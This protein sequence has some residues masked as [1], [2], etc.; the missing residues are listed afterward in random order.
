MKLST[1]TKGM[2]AAERK[3]YASVLRVRDEFIRDFNCAAF[4]SMMS[5]MGLRLNSR[6]QSPMRVSLKGGLQIEVNPEQFN[7]MQPQ[8]Q[9]GA[10]EHELGHVQ[11]CLWRRVDE[12]RNQ[13][14]SAVADPKR[15]NLAADA[16]V[17]Q[18]IP[19]ERVMTADKC[20]GVSWVL[21]EMLPG[22]NDTTMPEGLSFEKYLTQTVWPEAPEG[23]QPGQGQPRD[24]E[25]EP[26]EG[27]GQGDGEGSNKPDKAKSGTPRTGDDQQPPENK[28][29]GDDK[30]G[31]PEDKDGP[32][33]QHSPK[34]AGEDPNPH[35]GMLGEDI[36]DGDRDQA[37]ADVQQMADQVKHDG[38]ARPGTESANVLER[39]ERN[40]RPRN[41]TDWRSQLRR[42]LVHLGQAHKQFSYA[43]VNRRLGT[44]GD[45][46]GTG[47][48]KVLL[49]ID[50]SGSM[51]R[52]A[53]ML[54]C[55]QV[56]LLADFLKVD[57]LVGQCDTAVQSV[58]LYD[59]ERVRKIQGG[60]G[61][62][63]APA[64]E[65]ME[66]HK[67]VQFC[68]YFTDSGNFDGEELRKMRKPKFPVLWALCGHYTKG[69]QPWG[70][71]IELKDPESESGF[72]EDI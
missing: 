18:H 67:G 39:L 49:W 41:A 21:P 56:D 30:D 46:Y 52:N 44:P 65:W 23:G 33:S 11:Q 53:L 13:G 15:V 12:L 54:A 40:S 8:Y 37:D 47:A 34:P 17:N 66:K 72:S 4:G 7:A 62:H 55:D 6:M 63:F 71:E 26:Q 36:D 60:G 70:R 10:L 20:D 58:D 43:R 69:E 2:S 68:V 32:A 9:R 5:C 42:Y 28:N 61:T 45:Y 31:Q 51:D 27:E 48:G 50:T 38:T 19:L 14:V 24:G 35:E 16:A 59:H 25:G 22:P 29:G 1:S 3:A 64:F 57:I